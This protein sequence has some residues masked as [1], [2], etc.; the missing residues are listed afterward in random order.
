MSTHGEIGADA[1]PTPVPS[2][3]ALTRFEEALNDFG[4]CEFGAGHDAGEDRIGGTWDF[5]GATAKIT[6]SRA[7]VVDAYR[8]LLDEREALLAEKRQ[9]MA[10]LD[11]IANMLAVPA[12]AHLEG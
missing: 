4:G 11:E 2:S 3:E 9:T 7:R 1:Q 6:A 5:K 8:A 12:S 10:A